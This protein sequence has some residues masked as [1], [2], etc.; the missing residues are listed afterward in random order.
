MYDLSRRLMGI[1]RGRH[2]ILGQPWAYWIRWKW[3]HP[4][5]IQVRMG[6]KRAV[7][8]LSGRYA[9]ESI[10]SELSKKGVLQVLSF[11]NRNSQGRLGEVVYATNLSE[12]TASRRLSELAKAGVLAFERTKTFPSIPRYTL[13]WTSKAIARAAASLLLELQ[14]EDAAISKTVIVQE[15]C[16]I[17]SDKG[18]SK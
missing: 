9:L 13:P 18:E 5:N 11:F 16:K 1:R 4:R 7:V 17:T 14:D 12:R 15:S 2:R 6:S 3:I 8:P 10:L